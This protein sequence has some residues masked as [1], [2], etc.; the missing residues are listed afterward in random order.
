MAKAKTK[1]E[2]KEEIKEP[3]DIETIK[4]E[5]DDYIDIQIRKKVEEELEKTNKRIWREKNRKLFF[6]NVIIIILTLIII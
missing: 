3:F 4:S 1:E 5:L 6:K 2:V